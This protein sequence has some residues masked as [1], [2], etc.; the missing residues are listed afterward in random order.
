MRKIEVPMTL[1]IRDGSIHVLDL[2]TRMPFK[3]GIATMTRAPHAFVRLDVEI[4]GQVHAGIAA[5]LLPPK[6]FT[7]DPARTLE[8]EVAEM[9]RVIAHAVR[10]AI[11]M[12]AADA[13]TLWRQVWDEQAFWGLR[14]DLPPLLVH[15]G[16]SLVE[17]AV[18]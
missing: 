17:R 14:L 7:K 5:D 2:E 6:W 4:D 10:C 1:R 15:F 12:T 3:Y 18:I 11:G 16:T 13:F 8:D 9:G